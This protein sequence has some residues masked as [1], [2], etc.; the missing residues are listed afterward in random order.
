MIYM[1]MCV[2]TYLNI[3]SIPTQ[4]NGHSLKFKVLKLRAAI[5]KL[6]KLIL[7]M[8]SVFYEYLLSKYIWVKIVTC[9]HPNLFLPET[10][11]HRQTE[12]NKH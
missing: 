5:L 4:L 9:H 2:P 12:Q 6:A 7:F 1:Y 10:K 11:K 3:N 8:T